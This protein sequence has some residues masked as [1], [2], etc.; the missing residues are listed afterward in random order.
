MLLSVNYQR[1]IQLGA[2]GSVYLE[3]K[4]GFKYLLTFLSNAQPSGADTQRK[5][6][7]LN[8]FSQAM[9]LKLSQQGFNS[10]HSSYLWN[11]LFYYNIYNLSF[12]T[13][14]TLPSSVSHFVSLPNKIVNLFSSFT[15]HSLKFMLKIFPYSHSSQ[16][17]PDT[18]Q[19]E[20]GS[21][22]LWQ[23]VP[24][25]KGLSF[26]QSLSDLS[27]IGRCFRGDIM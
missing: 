18:F 26:G 17:I 15:T 24:L 4:S 27:G 2:L 23:N 16:I 13:L 12:R 5:L 11:V 22:Q 9:Q 3:G 6:S 14:L 21:E 8:S 20:D 10:G 1:E 19:Q 7:K 25:K